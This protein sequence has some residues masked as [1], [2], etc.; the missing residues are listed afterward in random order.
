M[1]KTTSALVRTRAIEPHRRRI[2]CL[3]AGAAA[4]AAQRAFAQAYP[5]RPVRILSGFPPGGVNDTYA[6][7]IAQWL[8]ERL[9]QQF[10]VE[11]RAGAGGNIAAETLVRAAPDGYTLLLTTSA[12]AWNATLYDN[13]KFNFLHDAMAV[14]AIS[15]GPGILVVHPSVAAGSV[16]ELIALAKSNPGRITI[17]SAGVGSAPHMYW[18][19][20]H[21]MTG[22]DML[23]V[24][25]RGGGPALTDLIGGQVQAYFGTTASA[26]GYVRSGQLRALAVTSA[27]RAPVLPDLPALAEFL[28]GYEASIFVGITAP[29]ATPAGIIQTLAREI[30]LALSDAR[31]LQR[32]SEL[33]DAPLALSSEEFAGLIAAEAEKWAKV[34][35]AANIRAE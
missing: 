7:L 2:L 23:H 18:E 21:S 15:R 28:P 11:N 6:R 19:L 16:P 29:R 8:S 3:A 34:I 22:V 9:G 30:N 32:I 17:A 12:D 35:R 5:A 26:I 1:S 4:L 10:F 20:F 27:A 25:Y 24:P 31:I 33:G 14:A 13:L